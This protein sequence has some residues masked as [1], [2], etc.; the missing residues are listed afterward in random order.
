[1]V[2]LVNMAVVIF[3]NVQKEVRGCYEKVGC[4]MLYKIVGFAINEAKNHIKIITKA[5]FKS[6]RIG[7]QQPSVV[8]FF[9]RKTAITCCQNRSNHISYLSL[10]SKVVSRRGAINILEQLSIQYINI[11]QIYKKEKMERI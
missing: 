10:L 5:A 7:D 4:L 1:M 6:G 8:A 3:E 2:I 9:V 11:V